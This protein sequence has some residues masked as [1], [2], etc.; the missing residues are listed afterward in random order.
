MQIFYC[1]DIIN[2]RATL[3]ADEVHHLRV[4]H[5]KAGDEILL[6]D[7]KGNKI[8]GVI[9]NIKKKEAYVNIVS[10]ESFPAVEKPLTVCIA[11]TKNLNRIEWCVEKMV[12]LGIQEIRFFKSAHS[13]RQDI[14]VDRIRKKVIS[15]AKQSY[16]WHHPVLTEICDF[17]EIIKDPTFALSGKIIAHLSDESVNATSHIRLMKDKPLVFLIGP[18]GD[19][20]DDELDIA[21]AN[22]W[23]QV[24]F[25]HERLRTETA[26]LY[27]TMLNYILDD[28]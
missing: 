15:A 23:K 22:G 3:T 12:E 24:Y 18:E 14:N 6:M 13:E 8:S 4:L 26:A 19:F 21:S 27:A 11:P 2:K 1:D 10:V 9:E 20:N 28:L 25:G 7:G 5:Y 16:K 17:E